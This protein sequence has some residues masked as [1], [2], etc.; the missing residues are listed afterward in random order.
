MTA[1]TNQAETD[2]G[3]PLDRRARA[4]R[5]GDHLDDLREQ[6]VAADPLGAHDEAAGRR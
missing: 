1:G 6:R 5:L 3:E 2:V 4:L